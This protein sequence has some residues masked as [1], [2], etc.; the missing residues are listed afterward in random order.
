MNASQSLRW[1]RPDTN[2]REIRPER[3]ITLNEEREGERE[4]GAVVKQDV[5]LHVCSA[6]RPGVCV[7]VCVVVFV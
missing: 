7:C 6:V 5:K 2:F 3:L 1:W 4:E